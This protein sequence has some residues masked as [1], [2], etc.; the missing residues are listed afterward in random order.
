MAYKMEKK[1]FF[2]VSFFDNLWIKKK[3]LCNKLILLNL[4]QKK[5]KIISKEKLNANINNQI[6]AHSILDYST[7]IRKKI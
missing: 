4:S 7:N 2:Y 5:V 6:Y 1:T 3:L